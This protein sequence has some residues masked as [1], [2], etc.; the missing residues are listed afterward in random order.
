MIKPEKISIRLNKIRNSGIK[1]I[2]E[3]Y[4]N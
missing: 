1:L 2:G 3:K 4:K